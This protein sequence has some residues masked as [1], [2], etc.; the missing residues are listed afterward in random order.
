[1]KQVTIE[2]PVDEELEK[3]KTECAKKRKIFDRSTLRQLIIKFNLTADD[4]YPS[5]QQPLQIETRYFCN[6][7]FV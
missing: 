6:L 3:L 4:S 5:D 2:G 1:M 7:E